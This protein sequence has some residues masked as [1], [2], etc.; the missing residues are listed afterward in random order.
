MPKL[1]IINYFNKSTGIINKHGVLFE[2]QIKPRTGR[3]SPNDENHTSPS[4][5]TDRDCAG[6]PFL[7][8]R[9]GRDRLP[10]LARMTIVETAGV[11]TCLS[12][13]NSLHWQLSIGRYPNPSR[14][15]IIPSLKGWGTQ[16][17]FRAIENQYGI[18]SLTPLADSLSA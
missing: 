1:T 15:G 16:N 14:I 11:S 8:P 9:N 3:R 17:P 13:R 5:I 2:L 6:H 12:G 4:A 18:S 7:T 10:D